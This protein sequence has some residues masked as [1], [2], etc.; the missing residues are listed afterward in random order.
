LLNKTIKTLLSNRFRGLLPVVVDVETSGLNPATDAML[1]IAAVPLDM[2]DKG[3]LFATQTYSYHVEPFKGANIDEKSLA[4]TGINPD[5]PFR[6]AIPE[7][8]ALHNIFIGVNAL[9]KTTGCQRAVLVGHNAW[10]DLAFLQAAA[11][12]SGMDNIPF[13]S[14]TTFDTATLAAIVFG[15]TV[16]AR[17]IKKANI[18]FNINEAHSAA[19]DAEK[20]AELFCQM[21]N[22]IRR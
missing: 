9:L 19:Y 13:H 10:F 8:Q 15:E 22:C 1:E 3:K 12:R 5:A 20:T 17:A 14:F 11:K 7:R 6:Y 16:L 21:V 2:N 4:I 18:S